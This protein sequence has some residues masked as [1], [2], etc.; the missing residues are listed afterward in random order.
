MSAFSRWCGVALAIGGVATI[1]INAIFTPLLFGGRIPTGTIPTTGLFLARQS[2]SA[3]AAMCILFGALGIGL[4]LLQNRNGIFSSSAFFLAFVGSIFV[5]AVEFSDVF[6]LHVVALTNT[7]VFS[8]IEKNAFLNTGMASAVGVFA[9][10]WLL[11]CL[12]VW[13]S[14]VLP[15][16]AALTTLAGLFLIP[17]LQALIGYRGAIIGNAVYGIG[18]A[19]LGVALSR[20]SRIVDVRPEQL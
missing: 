15:A 9:L 12:C 11:L 13:R 19:G 1:L 16:W 5:F 2:A 18:L 7:S 3:F 6:V 17:A 10:G 8:A 20:T 14:K 4:L